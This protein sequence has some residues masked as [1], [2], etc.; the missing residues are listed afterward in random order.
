MVQR[1]L[2][3]LSAERVYCDLF[4]SEIFSP[5]QVY[6]TALPIPCHCHGN[7]SILLLASSTLHYVRCDDTS[8]YMGNHRADS[9]QNGVSNRECFT[10]ELQYGCLPA[11]KTCS[12]AHAV[13]HI[14]VKFWPLKE[15]S[16]ALCGWLEV[17]NR[18]IALFL[19]WEETS[20]LFLSFRIKGVL[21][22]F[23]PWSLFIPFMFFFSLSN[24]P[25]HL[26]RIVQCGSFY[27]GVRRAAKDFVLTL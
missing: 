23:C 24:L 18:P 13:W 9:D 25:Q 17:V 16:S 1:N 3:Y 19:L 26:T 27:C 5:D 10:R 4:F 14:S 15:T 21:C 7:H 12:S 11:E 2:H 20:G 6:Q 22:F 8:T